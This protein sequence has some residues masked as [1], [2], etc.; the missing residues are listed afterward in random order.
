MMDDRHGLIPRS[1]LEPSALDKLDSS[2]SEDWAVACSG[3][4]DSVL[5]VRVLLDLFPEKLT[6]IKIFHYDH[7]TRD[8]SGSDVLFV[9]ELAQEL[10]LEC[11]VGKAS[12]VGKGS[13]A[14]LRDARLG[15]LHAEMQARGIRILIQG[16]Q[17]D[18]V[19]ETLLMRLSRGS[20]SNGLSAPRPV[21]HFFDSS[22]IHVRPLLSLSRSE[23]R[24]TLTSSKISWRD[25]TSNESDDYFRNR[26]RRYVVPS[27]QNSAQQDV[28]LSMGRTRK[29]LEEDAEALHTWT[30]QYLAEN[31][32]DSGLR[33]KGNIPPAVIRR[34]LYLWL[35]TSGSSR[36]IN[37]EVMDGLVDAVSRDRSASYSLGPNQRICFDSNSNLVRIKSH[38]ISD[39]RWPSAM[40]P[41]GSTLFLPNGSSLTSTI[42]D[43]DAELKDRIVKGEIS[44]SC[45][46]FL[47]ANPS[48]LLIR[49]RQQGDKYRP[50]G[51]SED[52]RL[53]NL[54]VNRKIPLGFRDQLP[55][56]VLPPD[57]V[58]WCPS[59]PGP[60]LFKLLKPTK[61]ILRV[62]F[63][64]SFPCLTK[65]CND[66][67]VLQ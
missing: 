62:D 40:L 35:R 50:L 36:I 45:T 42:V 10:T 48:T 47:N 3:G 19:A 23:V 49:Q 25:D 4:A 29:L 16:H 21:Q 33:F 15:F 31:Q 34:A 6:S 17:L 59:C 66:D 60:E 7:G 9:K 43:V 56:V 38:Q 41:V 32:C 11:I 53:Q 24:S 51:M 58:L 14:E 39:Y 61:N 8:D 12:E 13:E 63:N 37:A 55:V 46:I 18:D 20:G 1:A 27:L 64:H 67:S 30:L 28:L 57:L 65:S 44:P 26:I 2:Q 52:V 54:M 22:L 5:L